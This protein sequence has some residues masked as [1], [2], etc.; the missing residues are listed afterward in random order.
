MAPTTTLRSAA[1]ALSLTALLTAC[2]GGGGGGGGTSLTSGVLMDGAIGGVQ[3]SSPSAS[4]TTGSTGQFQCKTGEV[5]TFSIGAFG[6]GSV[7][8]QALVSPIDLTASSSIDDVAVLNMARLLQT[9]DEDGNAGNGL[10]IPAASAELLAA[11]PIDFSLDA[12]AFAQ[13]TAVQ[14]VLTQ[15]AG[16]SQLR[17]SCQAELHLKSS[18]VA[19]GAL[20]AGTTLPVCNTVQAALKVS[21][22]LQQTLASGDVAVTFQT[23]IVLDN[24]TFGVDGRAELYVDGVYSGLLESPDLSLP[25]VPGIHQISLRLVD[26][27]GNP[28]NAGNEDSLTVE[29]ADGTEVAVALADEVLFLKPFQM[30]ELYFSGVNLQDGETLQAQLGGQAITLQAYN[31][32]LMGVA[33]DLAAGSQLLEL[34]IAEQPLTLSID[35][36]RNDSLDT[37]A[38]IT[39]MLTAMQTEL[40]Q[41]ALTLDPVANAAQIAALNETALALDTQLQAVPTL[42]DEDANHLYLYL[43]ANMAG[44]SL[45][46]RSLASKYECTQI[47]NMSRAAIRA[48]TFAYATATIATAATGASAFGGLPGVIVA[49]GAVFTAY[50]ALEEIQKFKTAFVQSID[51]LVADSDILQEPEFIDTRSLYR[52]RNTSGMLQV[53]DGVA[54]SFVVKTNYGTDN[55]QYLDAIRKYSRALGVL[56]GVLQ[57]L[58]DSWSA[59]FNAAQVDLLNREES[60]D[61]LNYQV[62]ITSGTGVSVTTT[63]SAGQLV[64]EFAATTEQE[65]TFN[66]VNTVEEITT[67]YGAH[68]TVEQPVANSAVLEVVVGGE[69]NGTLTS[70]DPDAS[71]EIVAQ[72]DFGSVMLNPT[73][74]EFTYSSDA[75]T[76]A[77]NVDSFSFVAVSARGVPSEPASVTVNISAIPAP[78]EEDPPVSSDDLTGIVPAISVNSGVNWSVLNTAG[79]TGVI[80]YSGNSVNLSGIVETLTGPLQPGGLT[81]SWSFDNVVAQSG[82]GLDSYTTPAIAIGGHRV[83]LQVSN[84]SSVTSIA[85]LYIFAM[86]DFSGGIPYEKGPFCTTYAEN[87][88]VWSE[89]CY[90]DEAKTVMSYGYSTYN[91]Y[92]AG[93]GIVVNGT[94]SVWYDTDG[95]GISTP[96]YSQNWHSNGAVSLY[97][98]YP[99]SVL[100]KRIAIQCD[101]N[102]MLTIIV[103]DSSALGTVR[104]TPLPSQSCPI[105]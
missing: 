100:S 86:S 47:W 48:S 75:G 21:N 40:E 4:G 72:P 7:P 20:P 64:L 13:Q 39:T 34:T 30:F 61:P 29:V 46:P 62:V 52:I 60:S 43:D 49:G 18:L 8:C 58:P 55:P 23:T 67:P 91:E 45:Q 6:L 37:R 70:T 19:A 50:K 94:R 97:A 51:C 69:G 104:V 17:D 66:L 83:D 102:G 68:I 44:G 76:S 99:G 24:F 65:F 105:Q 1:L 88:E 82:D 98:E 101:E 33:P 93:L 28:I 74:G 73:T 59:S 96:D 81:F 32:A 10:T 90:L 89:S 38:D 31:G 9:L 92:V 15:V 79:F 27:A 84:G 80:V 22:G 2:G 3:Y 95:I 85:P 103:G 5:V 57:Y 56:Q 63:T 36:V 16:M 41:L 54:K 53:Q 35:V 26:L 14:N 87:G 77:P 71:F 42:S 11:G 12:T 78:P 25:L